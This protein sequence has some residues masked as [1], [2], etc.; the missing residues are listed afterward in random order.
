VQLNGIAPQPSSVIG[1]NDGVA[2]AGGRS[3]SFAEQEF[4]PVSLP[5]FSTHADF[6]VKAG[7]Q[8]VLVSA[9]A[10]D[11]LT[12]WATAHATADATWS[13]IALRDAGALPKSTSGFYA[14]SS[15]AVEDSIFILAE[16]RFFTVTVSTG[17]VSSVHL[18]NA[19]TALPASK[20]SVTVT[21]E[22][23]AWILTAPSGATGNL[24]GLFAVDLT[25][26]ASGSSWF[27]ATVP[28]GAAGSSWPT[29]RTGGA[30]L[31]LSKDELVL[32]G[33][34]AADGG[35]LYNEVWQA[36]VREAP[37]SVSWSRVAIVD[38][39][40]APA[41]R[42][43]AT[44]VQH[45][46]ALWLF[47][48]ADNT[49]VFDDVWALDLEYLQWEL[50]GC[51]A[52]AAFPHCRASGVRLSTA[53]VTDFAF[54]APGVSESSYAVA[55]NSPPK[56]P[57]RVRIAPDADHVQARPSHVDFDSTN[58]AIPQQV[59]VLAV[60]DL[61]VP[62]DVS[63]LRI[64]HSL[65]TEDESYRAA[66]AAGHVP[67]L[68]VKV[69]AHCGDGRC[70]DEEDE[71]SCARDCRNAPE[72]LAE[73]TGSDMPPLSSLSK[74]H[75]H[76]ANDGSFCGDGLCLGEDAES[77]PSDCSVQGS[78]NSCPK[79]TP[80]RCRSG[81]CATSS[82]V[83]S[84]RA[85]STGAQCSTVNGACRAISLGCAHNEVACHDGSCSANG[86]A[87][88]E[89]LVPCMHGLYRCFDTS[90]RE[91]C[92]EQSQRC[93]P[94][95]RNLDVEAGVCRPDPSPEAAVSLADAMPLKRVSVTMTKYPDAPTRAY[96]LAD[97]GEAYYGQVS[98]HPHSFMDAL[99]LA[100]KSCPSCNAALLAKL[101]EDER[102]SGAL[103][104]LRVNADGEGKVCL[105]LEDPHRNV[106]FVP[107]A[108]LWIDHGKSEAETASLCL[109]AYHEATNSW[110]CVD[111]EPESMGGR[112]RGS[113]MTLPDS[114]C[115][116]FIEDNCPGVTNP[117]QA[118]A[119]G[120]G[121]GDACDN[122]PYHANPD[123]EDV[124]A[125]GVRVGVESR[126]NTAWIRHLRE[127]VAK[128]DSDTD[129]PV[130][131]SL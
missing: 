71:Y 42:R 105:S 114:G 7:K 129:C 67:S 60:E 89:A 57:V 1:S 126:G 110:S 38:A 47:G 81:A 94:A 64:R 4:S 130:L 50:I 120:D 20:Q 25:N 73:L 109:G 16:G 30:L 61:H 84:L 15:D 8:V 124:C 36:N 92:D 80:I 11:H 62:G 40:V 106:S 27:Q 51:G 98:F 131:Q 22:G 116:A 122:C 49:Q 69:P 96:L 46:G 72:A 19:L 23:I 68:T 26:V 121:V 55:L 54:S 2:L 108:T 9:G 95:R 5:A 52:G 83:C 13:P 37:Q 97:E 56:A 34:E 70:T 127:S 35:M 79:E 119:D 66:E 17:E 39:A 65:V 123:Q 101:A 100:A 21:K 104:S 117:S 53:K 31:A 58:W 28:V 18:P 44:V 86:G 93:P 14:L 12:L 6:A 75:E 91:S 41:P 43:D 128:V 74:R 90:C 77:C 115:L 24:N 102:E 59:R 118:D 112:S 99:A 103:F 85:T 113:F 48:G 88:C 125:A 32:V 10:D 3:Y 33:G 29:A 45:D 78:D 111:E 87:D 82:G 76:D 63:R 107:A